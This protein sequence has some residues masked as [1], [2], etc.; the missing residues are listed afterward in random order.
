M[1]LTNT[2]SFILNRLDAAANRLL[3]VSEALTHP[4]EGVSSNMKLE[5]P[6][7]IVATDLQSN[8][9]NEDQRGPERD[10]YRGHK[11]QPSRVPAFWVVIAHAHANPF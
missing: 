9:G 5:I 1:Y 6:K 11:R 10:D 4:T 7:I 3:S 8:E 2:A